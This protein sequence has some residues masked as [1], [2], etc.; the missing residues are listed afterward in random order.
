MTEVSEGYII[1]CIR[2]Y[3]TTIEH[4]RGHMVTSWD[5]SKNTNLII[6]N[7]RSKDLKSI[8]QESHVL[9]EFIEDHHNNWQKIILKTDKN[10]NLLKKRSEALERHLKW[11]SK[12]SE[13]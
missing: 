5:F 10:Y 13:L 7:L 12:T 9:D 8:W 2:S 1:R 6:I 4:M 11:K 3:A